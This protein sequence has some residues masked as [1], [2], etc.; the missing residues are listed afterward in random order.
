[1]V[2]IV[3]IYDPGWIFFFI[4]FIVFNMFLLYHVFKYHSTTGSVVKYVQQ[5]LYT[6]RRG[7]DVARKYSQTP[8]SGGVLADES[9]SG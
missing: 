5:K 1:M 4:F 7:P 9:P 2:D 8:A 3:N 6:F